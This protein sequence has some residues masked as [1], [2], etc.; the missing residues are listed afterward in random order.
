MSE[1]KVGLVVAASPVE[2][3]GERAEGII[4]KAMGKLE[5][6]GLNV[7][8]GK[9]IIWNLADAI[10]VAEQLAKEGIDLLV[11]IH[12]T[13]ISDTIQY[14]LVTTIKAPVVLWGL[15]FVET[16]SIPCMQHFGSVL[17]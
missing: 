17:W 7:A 1:A 10:E 13:W 5:N 16:F 2:S 12:A 8:K 6:C 11:I 14:I 15:P 4:N 9:K 3:G